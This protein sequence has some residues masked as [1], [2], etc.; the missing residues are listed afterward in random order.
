MMLP[1]SASDGPGRMPSWSEVRD[2]ARHAEAV[3]LDS[4]WVCDHLLSEP[5]GQPVEGIAE[6][7]TLLSA[8]AASTARLTLGTLVTPTVLR[9]PALLAKMATGVDGI[10]DG[11]LVL[12]LGA[13]FDGTEYRMYG[14]VADHRWARF[15]EE[16]QIIVALLGGKPVTWSGRF[17][18]L[19][20]ATLLPAP[21]RRVPVMVACKGERTMRLTARYADAWTTAWYGRP[22]Q[23][24]RAQLDA[25]ARVLDDEGRDP[26]TLRRMVGVEVV[27]PEQE[28]ARPGELTTARE[29]LA[30]ALDG[31]RRLGIDELIFGL[32]PVTARSIDRLVDA[33][34]RPAV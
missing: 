16:L 28:P 27:D 17:H 11:R 15:E 25:M 19:R 33:L 9:H 21:V 23:P 29:D 6:G 3:G 12:G 32:R 24:L 7:W 31:Y 4:A 14:I 20:D 30:A 10:S 8:L 13:G 18:N 1:M 26:A 22:D 5:P 34:T 2:V